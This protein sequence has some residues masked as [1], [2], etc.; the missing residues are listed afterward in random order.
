MKRK[1]YDKLLTWKESKSRK[2]LIL[3]GARQ[4]GKTYIVREFCKNEYSKFC[5]VN[6]FE[7]E[8]LVSIYESKRN[9]DEKFKELL[10]IAGIDEINDDVVLFIDEIQQSPTLISNLKYICE[11]H[12]DL[13]L[14]C[15][16]SL[17]G[18]SLKRNKNKKAFPVGKVDMLDMYQLDFEEFLMALGEDVLINEIKKCYDKNEPMLEVFHNHALSYY[19][20]YLFVGGMPEA[21]DNFLMNGKSIA[22]FDDTILNNIV[23]AYIEDMTKYVE[24]NS[25]TIRIKATYSSIP[26]QLGNDSHKFQY[27]KISNNSRKRDYEGPLD[28]LLSS[29]IVMQSFNVKNPEVPIKLYFDP[30]TFKLY[31][32][33]IGILRNMLELSYLDVAQGMFKGLLAENYVAFHLKSNLGKSLAYFKNES[34]TVEIDFLLQNEDGVIP[35]EVKSSEN[36]QSKSLKSYVTNFEPK[37]SIRLSTKNFG[38]INNIKSI[39]LYAV[40]CIK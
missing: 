2:P 18:V 21:V 33:D 34:S 6:L 23:S 12:R 36:T 32:N 13:H 22:S 40:F 9:A 14:I 8:Y 11:E 27:S 17:L 24:N 4:V 19:N 15:A 37:Y 35:I 20:Q 1:M 10:A 26:S 29:H 16:G 25:E 3:S 38:Y 31:L 7:N 28:W 39:P 5:E 30:D